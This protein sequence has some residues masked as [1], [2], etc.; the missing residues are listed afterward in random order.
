M[1]E[2]EMKLPIS[3]NPKWFRNWSKDFVQGFRETY[4]RGPDYNDAMAAVTEWGARMYGEKGAMTFMLEFEKEEDYTW[5][6]LR[7]S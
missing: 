2:L 6:V 7:W 4:G 1:I 5:F 3:E